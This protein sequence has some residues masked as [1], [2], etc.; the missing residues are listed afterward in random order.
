M[1]RIILVWHTKKCR[2]QFCIR[3][4]FRV[5][6]IINLDFMLVLQSFFL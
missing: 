5:G 3:R 6:D 1:V 4:F 2:M